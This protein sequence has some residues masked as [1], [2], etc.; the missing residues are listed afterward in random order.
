MQSKL[1]F[2]SERK[3]DILFSDY[4]SKPVKLP[5]V[6]LA[7]HIHMNSFTINFLII[8]INKS[9]TTW[10]NVSF[11]RIVYHTTTDIPGAEQHLYLLSFVSSFSCP[12]NCIQ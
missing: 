3:C 12:C 6:S 5:F 1:S 9:L 2:I 4:S 7:F 11:L 8:S 10:C